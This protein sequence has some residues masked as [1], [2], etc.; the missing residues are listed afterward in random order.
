MAQALIGA[1]RIDFLANTAKFVEGTKRINKQMR[2]LNKATAGLGA[3]LAGLFAVS[4]VQAFTR[5]VEA[6]AEQL[7]NIGKTAQRL[8]LTTDALQELRHAA[9]LSGVTVQTFDM[10]MQRFTRRTAE[11]AQGTGE[12][13][14]AL[15]ELGIQLRDQN[16]NLR[17]SEALFGDVADA[18]QNV[19]N[20]SDQLRLSFKLF[21]S[22]G[23]RLIQMLEGGSEALNKMRR[24]ARDMG[25]VFDEAL[26]HQATES[27]DRLDTLWKVI[28]ANVTRTFA[29][30]ADELAAIV[31]VLAD[32]VSGVTSATV[33]VLKFFGVVERRSATPEL[34][35]ERDQ[36]RRFVQ[37]QEA[38]SARAGG[39]FV[40]GP[41]PKNHLDRVKLQTA[42]KRLAELEAELAEPDAPATPPTLPPPKGGSGSGV[43][44]VNLQ[45]RAVEQLNEAARQTV[46]ELEILE[47]GFSDLE[48]ESIQDLAR[49]VEQMGVTLPT[50]TR[51][52]GTMQGDIVP[53]E[54]TKAYQDLVALRERTEVGRIELELQREAEALRMLTELRTADNAT[55]QAAIRLREIELELGPQAAEQLREEV[56]ALEQMREQFEAL[57][58]GE[59]LSFGESFSQQL[60][61]M[62][63]ETKNVSGQMGASLAG[64][65]GP[66]GTF[67]RSVGNA[68]AQML[69]FGQTG[70]DAVKRIGQQI[71]GSIISSLVQMG[72]QMGINA[73]IAATLGTAAAAAGVGQA[74]IVSAAWAP[75][76]AFASLATLG[77]NAAPATAALASTVALSKTM[78]VV[79]SAPGLAEGAVNLM[80]PGGPRSDS[81]P[82]WLSRGESVITA[83]GTRSFGPFLSAINAGL[84]PAALATPRGL[85][86]GDRGQGITFINAT[87]IPLEPAFLSPNEVELRIAQGV[88]RRAPAAVAADLKRGSNSETGKALTRSY[89]VRPQR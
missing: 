51:D 81:I 65:F 11:A 71:L 54:V 75:A 45:R 36:L 35:K 48:S 82:A 42:Q 87:G 46:R 2:G 55:R 3:A 38:A 5:Q 66:G 52:M 16:G 89:N 63:K 31:T 69:V 28:D 86:Q 64:V 32:F 57:A 47:S 17:S 6:A 29:E 27:K 8:G 59:G 43:A 79:G 22:E 20:D 70:E 53:P 34:I 23:A 41:R 88:D 85:G 76:A 67:Q 40:T 44:A 9:E 80:G 61:L 73:L 77:G 49:V 26:I 78:A 60:E 30:M 7:D 21:D 19:E 37:E 84:D 4:S 25:L 39:G 56:F 72:V 33:E 14:A 24:D 74:A 1:L 50:I 83:A 18:L 15:Q 68:A 62:A 13:E 12:A 58:S 10:A